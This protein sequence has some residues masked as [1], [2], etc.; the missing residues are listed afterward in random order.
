MV[1]HLVLSRESS[2]AFPVAAYTASNWTPKH[3]LFGRVGPVVV[4][5]EVV[6]AAEGLGATAG[7]RAAENEDSRVFGGLDGAD[8]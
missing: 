8:V 2:V 5:V 1:H 7:K 3:G 6:P 4:A